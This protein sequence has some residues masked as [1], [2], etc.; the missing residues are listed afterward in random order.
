MMLC[1]YIFLL[2]FSHL[3][4]HD[5]RFVYYIVHCEELELHEFVVV[6]EVVVT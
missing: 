6:V 3:A 1:D 4:K 5:E 2:Y